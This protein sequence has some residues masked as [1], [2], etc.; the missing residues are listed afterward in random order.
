MAVYV[1]DMRARF[2]RMTM[3]HMLAD[4][5]DEL[6]AMA[7]L[8]GVARRWWQ[9]PAKT[10]GSYYDIALSKRVAAVAAGA[11]EITWRQAGAMNARRRATGQLGA[12]EDAERWLLGHAAQRRRAAEFP[13]LTSGQVAGM[14]STT[15]SLEGMP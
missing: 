7:D 12:P 2:G 11:I 10:S 1:D 6:H 8:I 13:A 9:S 14:D 3:C 15:Q 5:D 4:T